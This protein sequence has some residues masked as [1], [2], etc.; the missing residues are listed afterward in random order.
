MDRL[1][2]SLYILNDNCNYRFCVTQ[3][4]AMKLEMAECCMV[5]WIS[6]YGETIN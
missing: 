3:K 2:G 4:M 1:D 6:L 5:Q